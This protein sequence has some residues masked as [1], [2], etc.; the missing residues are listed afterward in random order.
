MRFT[1]LFN[2]I[3]SLAIGSL[4]LAGATSFGY[5]QSTSEQPFQR[6][7]VDLELVL[8]VDISQSMDTDEQRVQREGY[9]AALTSDEVIE[10]VKYGPKGRIAVAYLEW[11]GKDEHFI[12]AD[13][14]IISD[15]KSAQVF[16]SKIAEA[17]LRRVQRTS[18]S[19]ALG[20]AVAMVMENPYH[21]TRR[22]I[23][24]SGDGPN[25]QGG[26]VTRARDA[27]LSS[28]VTINGLPLMLKA[29]SISWQSML[30]LDHYYEDCVIGG[31]GAFSIPVRSKKTFGDAVRMKLVLEIAG[32]TQEKP[33]VVRAK[34]RQ[35]VKCSLFD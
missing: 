31:P 8:A 35:P 10:A 3:T 9:V 26:A 13:W 32:L 16:A 12:V 14:A 11:G 34:T 28:G 33:R 17:P 27:A 4:F 25:N 15:L 20:Q 22:V 7:N 23:D 5:A 2:R 19:S 29:E 21:G 30:H 6:A 24:I 18:I 1:R